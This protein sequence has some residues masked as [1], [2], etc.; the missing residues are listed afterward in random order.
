MSTQ[1]VYFTNPTVISGIQSTQSSMSG[2][3]ATLQQVF[4]GIES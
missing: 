1:T 2:S 4:N 3:V